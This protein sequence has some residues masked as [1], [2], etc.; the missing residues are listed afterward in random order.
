MFTV[1]LYISMTS[2]GSS[3]YDGANEKSAWQILS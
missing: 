2:V 1:L 3:N